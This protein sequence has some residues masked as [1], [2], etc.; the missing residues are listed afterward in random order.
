MVERAITRDGVL[1]ALLEGDV[2]EDYPDAHPFPS[3]LMLSSG[4]R[5]L[6][7]VVAFDAALETVFVVTAYDPDLGHF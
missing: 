5:P 1:Q 3:C 7:V 6:H 4:A 2:I